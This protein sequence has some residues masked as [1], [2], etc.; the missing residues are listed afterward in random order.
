[1]AY[2]TDGANTFT[3]MKVS[4]VSFTPSPIPAMASG[5]MGDYLGITAYDGNVYPTWTDN[6]LGY[7]MTY[8]SMIQLVVPMGIVGVNASY[9]NDTTFGNGNGKMDFG[10]TELL[11]LK[12]ENTGTAE[13]DSVTV[14][15][16]PMTPYITMLDSTEFYG[17]FAIG[18]SRTIYDCFKFTVADSIPNGINIP[19][20]VKA[21]D[22][23]DSVWTTTFSILS[24]AP[25]VTIMSHVISDPAREERKR[26]SRPG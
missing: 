26:S 6:R 18:G 2:S 9:M 21:R 14:T 12:M 24:H 3:D 13:A 19:F 1:M 25:A 23:K 22:K 17:D 4:D 10:E 15:V 7:C 8:V 11:G 20:L 16:T 5:Y